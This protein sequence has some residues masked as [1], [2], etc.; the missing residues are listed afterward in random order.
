M[1]HAEECLEKAK[2]KTT[3]RDNLG[4]LCSSSN[5]IIILSEDEQS[6]FDKN[7]KIH[8]VKISELTGEFS[9]DIANS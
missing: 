6:Q 1:P 5:C 8:K 9:P 7:R 4:R 2:I 3:T